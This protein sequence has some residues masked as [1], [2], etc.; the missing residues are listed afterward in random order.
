MIM[1][2]SLYLFRSFV[3]VNG[4]WTFKYYLRLYEADKRAC[5][6]SLKLRGYKYDRKHKAYI[7]VSDSF[8]SPFSYAV[9]VTK[10]Q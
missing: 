8:G 10:I 3:I 4:H 6:R 5:L 7:L 1:N 9:V 2:D